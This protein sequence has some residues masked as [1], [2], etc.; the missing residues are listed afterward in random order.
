MT[1]WKLLIMPLLLPMG[2]ATQVDAS[3]VT[4]VRV[5][6]PFRPPQ[7]AFGPGHRGIDL[8]ALWGQSVTS[9]ISG[10]ITFRG[11]VGG[12]PVVSVSDGLRM[13]SLEPVTTSMA[14]GQ[15]VTTGQT[16]GTVAIGGHCSLRCLH[17]GLRVDGEYRNPLRMH[18]RLLP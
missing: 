7:S 11:E 6:D 3:P 15:H 12:R 10:T 1:L 18:A 16:L 17:L 2:A 9:P 4:P 8:M 14:V 13:V 5:L